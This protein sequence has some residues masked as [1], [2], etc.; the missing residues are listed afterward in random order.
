VG[1]NE[2][3]ARDVGVE[4]GIAVGTSVGDCEDGGRGADVGVEV[5]IAVGAVDGDGVFS[6]I[7]HTGVWPPA[8]PPG[9]LV[10]NWK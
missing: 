2:V 1:D 4:V 9:I 5:G 10:L 7:M 6:L 3:G 8:P